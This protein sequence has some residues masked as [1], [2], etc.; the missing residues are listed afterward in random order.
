MESARF[1]ERLDEL[2]GGDAASRTQHFLG[3]SA[4]WVSENRPAKVLEQQQY[5]E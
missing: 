1:D 2:D 4:D 3:A 5:M